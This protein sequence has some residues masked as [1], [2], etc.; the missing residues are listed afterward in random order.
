VANGDAPNPTPAP[1]FDELVFRYTSG[2]ASRSAFAVSRALLISSTV[3]LT[4]PDLVDAVD[5]RVVARWDV[6]AAI[7]LVG[8]LVLS[9]VGLI[10]RAYG[11]PE[12]GAL[13]FATDGDAEFHTQSGVRAV[14]VASFVQGIAS[15]TSHG[16]NVRL[17]VDDG[18]A[19]AIGCPD[20]ATAD[21][22][23]A[24]LRL[25][26]VEKRCRVAWGQ[27]FVRLVV[28]VLLT[29]AASYA[30][31]LIG[32]SSVVSS[33]L[34]RDA[35][36]LVPILVA[37]AVRTFGWRE[38]SIGADGVLVEHIGFITRFLPYARIA[39]VRARRASIEFVMNDGE[40]IS[41][42]A[43]GDDVELK[44]GVLRRIE[45]AR[46][47]S[48]GAGARSALVARCGRP[49]AAWREALTAQ[50]GQAD[51]YRTAAVSNED[52]TQLLADAASAAEQRIAAAV[53][54]VATGDPTS[55]RRV[56]VAAAACAS[57]RMRVALERA[58]DDSL[59]EAL[60]DAAI[61]DD[62]PEPRAYPDARERS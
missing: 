32:E 28:A 58:A 38:L 51:G 46:V 3:L 55:R 50:I 36:P 9:V 26:A 2:R 57:P 33:N 43:N 45:Q 53:A 14:P 27:G 34:A 56:R 20:E 4:I 60:V 35:L 8:A 49:V 54:L 42:W 23:L 24:A 25:G 29:I 5:E 47:A 7:S 52:A 62:A 12:R 39:A 40:S 21:R 30:V 13:V 44:R 18:D 6:A 11:A 15:P 17:E 22:V 31:V 16:W 19:H 59:S 1:Q 48:V 10:A 61:D 37:W 41:V